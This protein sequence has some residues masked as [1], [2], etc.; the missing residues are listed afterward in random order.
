MRNV[1][2][3]EGVGRFTKRTDSNRIRR[4]VRRLAQNP[5]PCTQGRGQGEGTDAPIGVI[6]LPADRCPLTP[7]LSPEYRGE[8]ECQ[9]SFDAKNLTPCWHRF[10][11]WPR[12]TFLQFFD[13]LSDAGIS[14]LMR[15]CFVPRRS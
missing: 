13:P 14:M 10:W 1:V 8:G 9:R 5:L 6:R 11:R 15:M 3:A 12:H 2:P 4:P 7:T